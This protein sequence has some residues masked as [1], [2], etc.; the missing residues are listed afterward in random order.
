MFR[1]I[2]E[3]NYYKISNVKKVLL[4]NSKESSFSSNSSASN[5][6]V[7]ILRSNNVTTN[8]QPNKIKEKQ[9]AQ[10]QSVENLLSAVMIDTGA[11][12]T[13]TTLTNVLA[14]SIGALTPTPEIQ[15]FSIGNT[16]AI[17]VDYIFEVTTFCIHKK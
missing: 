11:S 1:Q 5:D 15:L 7:L 12:I 9:K 8:K 14:F 13:I 2:K 3:Q 17:I 6:S 10:Q 4:D 16:V